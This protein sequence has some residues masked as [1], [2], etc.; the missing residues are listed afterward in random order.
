MGPKCM[1]TDYETMG[2]STFFN[3]DE[4]KEKPVLQ[5]CHGDLSLPAK[6]LQVV[7]WIR[8]VK[9]R[10]R[11]EQGHHSANDLAEVDIVG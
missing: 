5:F 7:G 10:D 8:P 2:S 3:F 6:E 4:P 11:K 9:A 1:M